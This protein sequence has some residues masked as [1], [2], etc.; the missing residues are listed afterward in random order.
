MTI[1][2]VRRYEPVGLA[3][4]LY[5]SHDSNERAHL[6]GAFYQL[7]ESLGIEKDAEG[8]IEASLKSKQGTEMVLDT[9]TT[10]FDEAMSDVIISTD[11]KDYLCEDLREEYDVSD[12]TIDKLGETFTVANGITYGEFSDELKRANFILYGEENDYEFADSEKEWANDV[13]EKYKFI[14]PTIKILQHA[15]IE[16]L[17]SDATKMTF[18]STLE[19]ITEQSAIEKNNLIRFK[20]NGTRRE[21]NGT[22]ENLRLAA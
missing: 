9:Y 7:G 16:M 13:A 17:K 11:L 12:E 20:P 1:D 2:D 22:R 14:S 5:E 6:R 10:K 21:F 8:F 18:K 3:K 19:K 4:K 15:K